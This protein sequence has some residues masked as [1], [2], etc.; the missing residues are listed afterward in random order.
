MEN[1]V[2][3]IRALRV[4]ESEEDSMFPFSKEETCCYL[5][6]AAGSDSC[7]GMLRTGL[8]QKK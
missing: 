5:F 1:R 7:V 6:L 4:R 3:W 2:L 8:L